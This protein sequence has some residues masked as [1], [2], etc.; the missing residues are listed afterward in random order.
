MW[1]VAALSWIRRSCFVSCECLFGQIIVRAHLHVLSDGG[2][3]VMG[4]GFVWG[5]GLFA[6]ER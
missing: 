5:A 3:L 4:V 2:L 6:I 1:V